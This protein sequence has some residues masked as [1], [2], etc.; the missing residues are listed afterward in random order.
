M[1]DAVVK[2]SHLLIQKPFYMG[3]IN[4]SI[5]QGRKLRHILVK[6]HVQGHITGNRFWISGWQTPDSIFLMAM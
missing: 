2:A 3:I 6:L 1:P 4:I 5:S